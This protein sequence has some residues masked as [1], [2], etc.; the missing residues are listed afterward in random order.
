MRLDRVAWVTLALKRSVVVLTLS[1]QA[2]VL[3]E[4]AFVDV[5]EK[6]I[7]YHIISVTAF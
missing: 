4:K 6:N 5:C 2:K 3:V 1:V 7:S